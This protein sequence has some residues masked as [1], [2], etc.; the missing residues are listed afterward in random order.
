[1]RTATPGV[2]LHP[3]VTFQSANGCSSGGLSPTGKPNGGCSSNLGQVYARKGNYGGKTAI[4]YTYYMPKDSPSS[5]LGHRHEWE[6]VVVWLSDDSTT[7]EPTGMAVSQ[8]GNYQKSQSF[9]RSG[10]RPLV[11]YLSIWPVNHQMIFT[12]EQGGEQP[13]IAWESLTD[14]ARNALENTDFG[15]A[16]VPFKESTF[17]ANLAKAAL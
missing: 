2:Y 5:G 14:A 13:L 4:M 9:P 7:A 17:L 1:M 11:G 8:H 6:N 16:T 10:S 12:P 15:S 3:T